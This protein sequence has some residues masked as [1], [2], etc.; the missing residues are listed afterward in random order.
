MFRKLSTLKKF[1]TMSSSEAL[2]E[3]LRVHNVKRVYGIVG[4]A[5]MNPLHSFP[6]AGIKFIS[7]QHE[8]NAVHMADGYARSSG[9]WGVCI[10]QNGPGI[11]NMVTGVAT[12]YY[13]HSPVVLITPQASNKTFGL[14]MFQEIEQLSLFSKITKYQVQVND[15]SR[16]AEELRNCFHYAKLYNGP[17]QLNIPRELLYGTPMEYSILGSK[18]I[19]L[20]TP[21][22]PELVDEAIKLLS[23][24]K[25][26]VLLVGGGVRPDT[27]R[28]KVIKLA[29]K[30]NAGVVTTYLHND[31]FP[32]DHPLFAGSLGYM[33]AMSGMKLIS[34]ADVVVAVGTR[35]SKFGLLPQYGID[36]WPKDAKLI[37]I[38]INADA[39]GKTREVDIGLI[40]DSGL[41]CEQLSHFNSRSKKLSQKEKYIEKLNDEWNKELENLTNNSIHYSDYIPPRKA[42]HSIFKNLPDDSIISTDI[43]N[44]C[45][46]A[47]NYINCKN[48]RSFLG[49]MTFGSCGTALPTIIGAKIANPNKTCISISGDGAWGM[50]FFELITSIRENVPV[51]AVVFN[52]RQWGAEK[53]NQIIWFGDRYVGTNLE[54]PNFAEIAEKMGCYGYHCKTEE[55]VQNAI[56]TSLNNTDKTSVIEIM[57]TKELTDPFRRDAMQLPTRVLERYLQDNVIE[58]SPTGQAIDL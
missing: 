30:L 21:A 50:S 8:Q 15:Q 43:G 57:V 25:R 48:P 7:V 12:A 29:E 44:I 58:E 11:T 24:A 38:D 39:V 42:L 45:S 13:A 36:Y 33:G 16:I 10:S 49:S 46:L 53:K 20:Q 27:G 9:D 55:D 35:L 28:D 47:N 31:S 32:C 18:N 41:V 6:T 19:S 5:F 23:V 3:T 51:I 2:V 56:I 26:P 17:T 14:G 4:S 34:E 1:A 54:N 40:G 22:N 37:Q 52:N